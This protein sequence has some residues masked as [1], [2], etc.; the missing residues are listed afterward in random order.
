MLDELALALGQTRGLFFVAGAG[1]LF[2]DLE[3]GRGVLDTVAVAVHYHGAQIFKLA[4]GFVEFLL[5]E[6]LEF[7]KVFVAVSQSFCHK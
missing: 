6:R 2:E 3:R 5:Y 1:T 4:H 7:L